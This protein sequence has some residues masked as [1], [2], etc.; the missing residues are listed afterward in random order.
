MHSTPPISSREPSP[1]PILRTRGTH[2]HP[3]P[4]A[5]PHAPRSLREKATTRAKDPSARTPYDPN[6]LSILPRLSQLKATRLAPSFSCYPRDTHLP[7]SKKRRPGS[8]DRTIRVLPDAIARRGPGEVAGRY[9]VV[10]VIE[11]A[12]RACAG[13]GWGG[14]V[15]QI[16]RCHGVC[17]WQHF[18]TSGFVRFAASPSGDLARGF[19][20][21]FCFCFC[22]C[23]LIGPTARVVRS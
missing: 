12:Y 11:C 10:D 22:F 20:R 18:S 7:G 23:L 17:W 4:R 14:N 8:M 2:I 13:A 9:H 6:S 5:D 1:S 3:L 19:C 21:V 15:W 16:V